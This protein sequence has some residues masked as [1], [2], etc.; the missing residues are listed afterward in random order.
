M[1]E[2]ILMS[3]LYN[4]GM[5]DCSLV[6]LQKFN[7]LVGKNGSGKTNI[8]RAICNL[9][10]R[11]SYCK[12]EDSY[13]YILWNESRRKTYFPSNNNYDD[14]QLS[15]KTKNDEIVFKGHYHIKGDFIRSQGYW[16]SCDNSPKDFELNLRRVENGSAHLK[17]INFVINYIF[18]IRIS[19][20]NDGVT[21]WFIKSKGSVREN[22]GNGKVDFQN[23]SSGYLRVANIFLEILRCDNRII[24]LDEPEVHLEA[25]AVRKFYE[26]LFWI[27]NYRNTSLKSSQKKL[28][29]VVEDEWLCWIKN[30]LNDESGDIRDKINLKRFNDYQYF[31][32][33]HSSVLLNHFL[34]NQDYCSVYQLDRKLVEDNINQVMGEEGRTIEREVLIGIIR[35]VENIDVTVLNSLGVRGSDNLITNGVIW[36]EG[37]SDV[38]YIRQWLELFAN[39]NSLPKLIQGEDYQ[40]QMYGGSLLNSLSA[41]E[42]S[43]TDKLIDVLTIS[44]KAYI[45]MDS[46]AILEGEDIIVLTS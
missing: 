38:I 26:V 28:Y 46:D 14:V 40:F 25:R 35:K 33:T 8:L 6:N 30:E 37:P 7:L 4:F 44:R 24:C 1:I 45:V 16:I 3:N 29:S 34:R 32:S 15:I 10:T 23:W 41:D 21:E 5:E 39:E 12:S 19:I 20:T 11:P 31:L 27:S 13:K 36:V 9:E 17:I 2:S 18:G 42:N 22:G 43:S